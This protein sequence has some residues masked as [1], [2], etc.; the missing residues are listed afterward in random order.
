MPNDLAYRRSAHDVTMRADGDSA[1]F[2]GYATVYGF[3]YDVDGGPTRSGWTEVIEAGAGSNTLKRNPDVRLL[4]NHEGAPM[5]R[6]GSANPTMTLSEDHRGL[7]VDAPKLDLRSP[8]VQTVHSAM[9]RGD[10]DEMSFAFRVLRQEWNDDYTYRRI[11]EYDL[12][13]TGADV[14]IVNYPANPATVAQIRAEAQIDE[15][16]SAV[17]ASNGLDIRIA[18]QIVDRLAESAT[19]A[20]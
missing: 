13:V 11:L 2:S 7:F 9:T 4:L 19:P 15:L 18:R 14:S 16:R 10:L 8:L 12:A 1:R 3:E 20:A 17:Q 5:A 6:S